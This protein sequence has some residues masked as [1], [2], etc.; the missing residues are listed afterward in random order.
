LV[1]LAIKH[2]LPQGVGLCR[3]GQIVGRYDAEDSW[4]RYL[5]IEG[6]YKRYV[7][8]ASIEPKI[9]GQAVKKKLKGIVGGFELFGVFS[10]PSEWGFRDVAQPGSALAWGARGR[11]FESSRPDNYQIQTGQRAR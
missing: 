3:I 11:W 8:N 2:G 9:L 1:A 10:R 7:F 4:S 6:I 5:S